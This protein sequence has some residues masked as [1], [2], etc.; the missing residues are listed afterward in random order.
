MV[1]NFILLVVGFVILIMSGDKLVDGAVAV[2]NKAKISPLVI[3]MTIVAFGTS[4]PELI[5]NILSAVKGTTDLAVGNII[6]SNIINV[7][8]IL[9]VTAIIYPLSVQKN[10][11]WIEVPLSLLAVVM[12]FVLGNDVL[13]DRASE[14]VLTR[15][16]GIVLLAFFV[17]FLYYSFSI[18]KDGG[19]D[20]VDIP[21]IKTFLAIIFILGGVLGLFLGGKLIV[22]SAVSIA[23]DFGMSEKF[24]GLTIVALG[25]SLPELVTSVIAAT[26]KNSDIAIGNVVGSNIF[27]VF[28]VLGISSI[29]TPI[30]LTASTNIDILMA[31]FASSLMFMFI[32]TRDKNRS[33][34]RVEGS[35]FVLLY[36]GY[37]G[38]LI[39]NI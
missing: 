17:V 25:T 7:M 14:S 33:I 24:I 31:I 16:D 34:D 3:G 21:Q 20:E 8:I 30:K 29:I 26:K 1:L 22:D 32:F 13:I 15:S 37:L 12:V 9:G 5:V 18:A 36:A 23:K 11:T 38:Y 6:G 39:Y 10:T 35:I 2:A 4:A 19:D 28:M 27:N